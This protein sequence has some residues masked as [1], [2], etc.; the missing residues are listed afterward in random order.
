MNAIQTESDYWDHWKL[1]RR[2]NGQLV[3]LKVGSAGGNL[4]AVVELN[5]ELAQLRVV[6]RRWEAK[7]IER[8]PGPSE[9]E[10][11]GA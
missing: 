1:E 7:R 5:R 6:L 8:F 4:A 2:L 3:R 11:P 10:L 9:W